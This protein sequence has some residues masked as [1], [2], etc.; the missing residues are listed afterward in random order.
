MFAPD[1]PDRNG[2]ARGPKAATPVSRKG[3]LPAVPKARR[4]AAELNVSLEDVRA[5][6][7]GGVITVEDVELAGGGTNGAVAAPAAPSTGRRTRTP[8]APAAAPPAPA[9]AAPAR[10]RG[11]AGRFGR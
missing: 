9:P 2:S 10:P 7:P 4:R 6:G 5:T 8:P 1:G 3:P 11:G